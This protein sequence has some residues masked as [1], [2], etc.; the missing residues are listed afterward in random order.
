MMIKKAKIILRNKLKSLIVDSMNGATQETLSRIDDLIIENKKQKEDIYKLMGDVDRLTTE[1]QNTKQTANLIS[2]KIKP[3]Q[4]VNIAFLIHNIEAIDSIKSI[5]LTML[6][7][8]RFN[9]S[10]FSCNRRFPG[11]LSFIDEDKVHDYLINEGIEHIRLNQSPSRINLDIIKSFSPDCLFRQSQWD[12][13]FSP[14]LST[15][16][17]RFCK[18]FYVPYE[19][20]N[21]LDGVDKNVHDSY[22]H[23]SCE[24]VFLASEHSV[25]ED[26]KYSTI[27][28]QFATGHP[29]VKE[30][31][32]ST[33]YWPVH[34]D[35]KLKII[36]G[37]H[38]SIYKGW[39]N[40]GVF[41]DSYNDMLEFAKTNSDISIIFSPHPAL[42]TILNNADDNIKSSYL[43]FKHEWDSL[44]NTCVFTF[45]SYGGIFSS[46]DLLV[47][48]GI[49][50]LLEY[51]TQRKPIVFI[52]REDHMPFDVNGIKI[53]K[54]LYS[55]KNSI[56]A[57]EMITKF[58]NGSPHIKIKA[59][60]EV[61]GLYMEV[62]NFHDAPSRI[63]NYIYNNLN[64]SSKS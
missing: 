9:V 27:K 62:D 24:A 47:I 46:S 28:N 48:D 7:D 54:G 39:S 35:F 1:I 52:E 38:H 3:N 58:K 37:A 17:L 45:S 29:K 8:A 20:M 18:I 53:S 44:P 6:S 19:I 33:P 50:W 61:C 41:L 11:E 59:Q 64:K 42:V 56:E 16:N 13:D 5:I 63:S 21:F 15:D 60:D 49:S 34:G 26:S 12:A 36:W 43:R 2:R 30:L 22:F 51:Q 4:V 57:I 23:Q 40:F 55:V 10:V 25:M 14:E 31:K 32:E